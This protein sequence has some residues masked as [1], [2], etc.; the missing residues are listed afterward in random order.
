[1]PAARSFSSPPGHSTDTIAE[2]LGARSIAVAEPV[3][4]PH[5][6]RVDR[7]DADLVE[8]LQGRAGRRPTRT[9]RVRCRGGA[10]R[11]RAAAAGR[12]RPRRRPRPRTS[13]PVTG[14]S[15]RGAPGRRSSTPCRAARSATCSPRRRGSRSG[16]PRAAASPRPG[17]RRARVMTSWASAAARIASRS[18]T[19]PVDICT[20]LKATTSVRSSI[21]SASRAGGTVVTSSPGWTRNGKRVDVNSISGITTRLPAGSE[22]ATRPTRPETVAPIATRPGSVFD[23]LARTAARAPSVASLQPSQLVRPPRHSS[24]A[25]CSASQPA[26]GGRP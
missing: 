15:R 22:A 10:R 21:A 12:C 23:E 11:V 18:A 14:R 24:S 9:R 20:A 7:L 16:R 25:C 2:L 6:V 13:P 8:Q 17:W 19:S 3:G 4:Q 26:C 5:V 1:M